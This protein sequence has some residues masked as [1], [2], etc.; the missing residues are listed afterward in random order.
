MLH[1][2]LDSASLRKPL[3]LALA[4][5]L[6]GATMLIASLGAS[7]TTT[8]AKLVFSPKPIG[9]AATVTP[10][11][12]VAVTLTVEDSTGAAIPGGVAYVIFSAAAGGGAAHAG[13]TSLGTHPTALTADSAGHIALTYTSP[14]S[15]PSSGCDALK[16]QNGPTRLTSTA[17]ASD[18]FCFTNI[19]AMSFSPKPIARKKSLGANTSVVVTLT[20]LGPGAAPLANATVWLD[21]KPALGTSG[22]TAK[23]NGL[24]LPTTP[25]AETTDAG[26]HVTVTYSTGPTPPATGS[27]VLAAQDAATKPSIFVTDQYTY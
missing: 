27:D 8:V 24:A 11:S 18:A 25:T 12:T 7:A 2:A 6:T 1:S 4:A 10:G 22:G 23:V 9:T 15:Y 26:G 16:A 20:V 19:T 14:A 3:R 21:F 5:V 13:T 17:F